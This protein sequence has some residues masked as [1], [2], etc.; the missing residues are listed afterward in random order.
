MTVTF[1]DFKEHHETSEV[2]R[3]SNFTIFN[4]KYSMQEQGF[5]L[6]MQ[7]MNVFTVKKFVVINSTVF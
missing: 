6:M 2:C 3:I 4:T 5:F 1:D 7:C